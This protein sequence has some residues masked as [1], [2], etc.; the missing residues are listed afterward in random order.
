MLNFM[1]AI[2]D[3]ILEQI[4]TKFLILRHYVTAKVLVV[5]FN[6]IIQAHVENCLLTCVLKGSPTKFARLVG[7]ANLRYQN[8]ISGLLP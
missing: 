6:W 1:T 8:S 5:C 3:V 4:L 2:Y 7:M